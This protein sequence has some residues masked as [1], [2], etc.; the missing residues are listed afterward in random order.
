M[1]TTPPPHLARGT[2]QATP[3]VRGWW[4]TPADREAAAELCTG[5]C[6]CL[7][8]CVVWAV[9]NVP[10]SDP[11]VWGGLMPE[12]RARIARAAR[13]PPRRHPAGAGRVSAGIP[14]GQGVPCR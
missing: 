10:P 2:C 14:A 8:A 7:T 12:Q 4:D 13:T 3:G 5:L 9:P 1:T 6:P 11:G